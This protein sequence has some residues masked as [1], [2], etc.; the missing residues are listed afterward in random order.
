MVV[1][2]VER[3]GGVLWGERAGGEVASHTCWRSGG[4]ISGQAGRCGI[5]WQGMEERN[6]ASSQGGRWGV[7]WVD[8]AGGEGGGGGAG[9]AHAAKR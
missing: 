2:W 9:V 8:L 4:V 6:G 7:V 3:R 5:V 1:V